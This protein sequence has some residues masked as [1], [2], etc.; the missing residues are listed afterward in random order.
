M[1]RVTI[2]SGLGGPKGSRTGAGSG[3]TSNRHTPGRALS[4]EK[5]P[6][7]PYATTG[8][9]AETAAPRSGAGCG[10]VAAV[11]LG[12]SEE[13]PEGRGAEGPRTPPY[14]GPPFARK[15]KTFPGLPPPGEGAVAGAPPQRGRIRGRRAGGAGVQERIRRDELRQVGLGGDP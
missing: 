10:G 7:P 3:E 13:T 12:R 1:A 2:F 11:G 8:E 15:E 4:R 5:R 14:S 9:E 6:S